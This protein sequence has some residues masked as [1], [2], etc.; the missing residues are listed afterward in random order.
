MRLETSEDLIATRTL[1]SA[2]LNRGFH[3]NY[4]ARV[5]AGRLFVVV[6]VYDIVIQY[7]VS[8]DRTSRIASGFCWAIDRTILVL[9]H[10]LLLTLTTS[11]VHAAETARSEPWNL[12]AIVADDLSAWAVGAYGNTEVVTPNLDKLASEG[13][14]LTNFF[15]TASVCTPSRA[16][17]LTGLYSQQSGITD[18]AYLRDRLEALPLGV[19]TW[20][21]ELKKHDYLTGLIGKWHLGRLPENHPTKYGIDYFFG[22]IGGSNLPIDPVL[23]RDGVNTQFQGPLP[24][25]LVDDAIRFVEDNRDN[26]FA[27]MLHFREPHAPHLPVPPEDLEPFESLEPTVEI[28]NPDEAVMDDDQE[29]PTRDSI[30]LHTRLLRDKLK[31]YYASVHSV[32]R[33]LGRLL[34]AL[35]RLNL[36]KRT[37]IVFTSDNGYMF[38][39][40]GLKGKGLAQPIWDHNLQNNVFVVNMFE[41]SIRVPL[42][43]RWPGVV[44]SGVVIDEL[45]S[46]VDIYATYLGMLGIPMPEDTPSQGMDFSTLLRNQK[47]E[48][49]TT[50]FADFTP[51]QTGNIEFFRMARTKRWKLIKA[52]LNPAASQLYDLLDDPHERQNLYVTEQW[53]PKPTKMRVQTNVAPAATEGHNQWMTANQL[54]TKLPIQ[55]VLESQLLEW[56]KSIDDPVLEMER[57]WNSSKAATLD[58]WKRN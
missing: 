46:N 9:T 54:K 8:V 34:A 10:F 37:I 2:C 12:I 11:S 19:P 6:H 30:E 32:D 55:D 27:L 58:R 28:V 23:E 48:W 18:V 41:E 1:Y 43:V 17:Y 42:I 51:D 24:D 25:I 21:R 16:T 47:Y 22:F 26:H 20:P 35:D 7:I 39:Q 13:A 31:S 50:L 5:C 40:R 52:Y 53:L 45:A 15:V 3:N 49:R 36:S 38:G 4:L 33:N 57:I 29:P 14:K 56:Q 44:T